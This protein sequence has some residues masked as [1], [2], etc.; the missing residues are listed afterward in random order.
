MTFNQQQDE[1]RMQ[2]NKSKL[3]KSTLEG[4]RT[5]NQDSYPKEEAYVA[6]IVDYTEESRNQQGHIMQH[7]S[8][9]STVKMDVVSQTN[10]R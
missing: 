10:E 1:Q 5:T 2:E 6:N 9:A 7:L 8:N 4:G 3:Q